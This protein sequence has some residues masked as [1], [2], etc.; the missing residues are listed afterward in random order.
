MPWTPEAEARLSRVPGFV[1]TVVAE[2]VENFAR[3]RGWDAVTVEVMEEVRR[4]MPVDFSK[5]MPFFMRG[6]KA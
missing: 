3:E 1:R 2:R 4:S 6:G 5:R